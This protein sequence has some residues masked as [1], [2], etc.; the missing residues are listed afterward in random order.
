MLYRI[1]Y[2]GS[3]YVNAD[4]QDEALQKYSKGSVVSQ[5][6]TIERV[7]QECE[8]VPTNVPLIN[9]GSRRMSN[10]DSIEEILRINDELGMSQYGNCVTYAP[11][12]D[13]PVPHKDIIRYKRAEEC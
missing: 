6:E 4:S 11:D 9:M 3:V 7:L 5:E 2:Q 12:P 13:V 1:E 10:K 8:G